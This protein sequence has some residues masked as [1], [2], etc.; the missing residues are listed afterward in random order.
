MLNIVNLQQMKEKKE[1]I[2]MV[3]AYDY[4]S[5]KLAEQAGVDTI[6]V[7]DSLGNVVL[8]YSSTIQVTLADMIHHAKAVKRGAKDTFVAVNLPFMSYH[9]SFQQ[10]I[11]NAIKIFQETDAQAV[12]VEGAREET[13][14]FISRLSD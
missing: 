13:L 7:G 6:L 2:T 1:K 8:G 5:A 11:V 9:A 14:P 12:K 4:P 10:S 3:T